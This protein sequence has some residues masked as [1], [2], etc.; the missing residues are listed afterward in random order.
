ML[1]L[2]CLKIINI[3]SNGLKGPESIFQNQ[4]RYFDKFI[5]KQILWGGEG[6]GEVIKKWYSDFTKVQPILTRI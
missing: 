1:S 4:V 5:I 3:P 2:N 6:G